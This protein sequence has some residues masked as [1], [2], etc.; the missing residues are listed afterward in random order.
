MVYRGDISEK[1]SSEAPNSNTQILLWATSNDGLSFEKKGIALDSRNS[2]LQGLADGPEFVDFN[3]E[4]RVY[5]WS[6]KGVYHTTFKDN[7]FSAEE[8]DF[9]NTPGLNFSPTPPGDPTIIK[10]GDNWFMYYGQHTKGI[11]YATLQG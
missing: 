6:Y 8:F 7:K 10:I 1:Y 11:Y 5:F 4:I 3:G 2:E 9:S